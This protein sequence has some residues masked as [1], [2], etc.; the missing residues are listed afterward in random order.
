ME[1]KKYSNV[2]IF[3]RTIYNNLILILVTKG[4]YNYILK[5]TFYY[6]FKYGVY[7]IKLSSYYLFMPSMFEISLTY[8]EYYILIWLYPREEYTV[9][10]KNFHE[11][12]YGLAKLL[13]WQRYSG[14]FFPRSEKYNIKRICTLAS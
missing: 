7:N 4:M 13:M 9:C 6:R 14:H 8:V 12:F 1:P 2:N 11:S 5:V 10:I 3:K